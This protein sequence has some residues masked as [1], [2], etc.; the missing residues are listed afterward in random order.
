MS[1]L[2]PKLTEL[3]GLMKKKD[4]PNSCLMQR[5]LKISPIYS[6]NHFSMSQGENI[7]CTRY[8]LAKKLVQTKQTA[9]RKMEEMPRNN[10]CM[11]R[12]EKSIS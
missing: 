2:L 9:N 7:N 12:L 1:K 6:G 10:I 8:A 5:I 4:F 3:Y 11:M